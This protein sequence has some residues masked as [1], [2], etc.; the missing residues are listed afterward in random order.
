MHG[1]T[2]ENTRAGATGLSAVQVPPATGNTAGV[3][4]H[5]L[6]TNCNMIWLHQI[7]PVGL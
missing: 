6:W 3:R 4:K 5:G 7:M 2:I 1:N